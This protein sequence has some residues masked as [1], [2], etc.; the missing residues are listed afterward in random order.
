MGKFNVGNPNDGDVY[1]SEDPQG[2]ADLSS[3]AFQQTPTLAMGEPS[4]MGTFIAVPAD[5]IRGISGVQP[6]IAFD[7]ST[8]QTAAACTCFIPARA[9]P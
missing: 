2:L 1:V 7:D 9:C 8:G 3:A 4:L 5:H 6:W